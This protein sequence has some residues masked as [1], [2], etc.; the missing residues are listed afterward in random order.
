MENKLIKSTHQWLTV[1]ELSQ[2][3]N[4][5]VRRMQEIIHPALHSSGIP[6]V[7]LLDFIIK[8]QHLLHLIKC[9]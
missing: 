2:S 9:K 5:E 7:N 8:S 6:T 1:L 4:K 3:K